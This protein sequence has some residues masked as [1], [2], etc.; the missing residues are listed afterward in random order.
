MGMCTGHTG[1][2]PTAPPVTNCP[3][4]PNTCPGNK[5]AN[6]A[7][8]KALW[9]QVK[10]QKPLWAMQKR[11]PPFLFPL[12]CWH[13]RDI[14]S[15]VVLFQLPN[16]PPCG[17]KAA[18]LGNEKTKWGAT[19]FIQQSGVAK[20]GHKAPQL[21]LFQ[22]PIYPAANLYPDGNPNTKKS[23]PTR[24]RVLPSIYFGASLVIAL[25]V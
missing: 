23:A 11:Q 16:A 3:S 20:P 8:L 25:G 7:A 1:W 22:V 19:P 9:G 12:P 4:G 17:A 6:Q 13:Q 5:S 18:P 10:G 24:A 21:P 14:F 2:G 15:S